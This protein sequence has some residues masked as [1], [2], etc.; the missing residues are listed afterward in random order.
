MK[1]RRLQYAYRSTASKLHKAVGDILRSSTFSGY[2]IFQEYP[3]NRINPNFSD[4][5]CKF[6][7]VIL[8][9]KIVLEVMGEQHFKEICFG[10]DPEKSVGSL[11][12]IKHRD[13][14]KKEAALL[15]GFIYITVP[16]WDVKKINEVYLLNL[17]SAAP[18]ALSITTTPLEK[19]LSTEYQ[20][21]AKERARVFR[22]EQYAKAKAY[23]KQLKERDSNGRNLR[24]QGH[25]SAT[26]DKN[27][28]D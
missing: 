15:A 19:P 14:A 2:R 5:R 3:V 4:G 16:Y 6:D 8:D 20:K 9:L 21:V 24:Y 22:K 7:W 28:E 23:R 18:E 11:A 12:R 13:E 1:T 25:D 27:L 10:G 17:I 26:Q